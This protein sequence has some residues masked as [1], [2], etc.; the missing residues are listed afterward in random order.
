MSQYFLLKKALWFGFSL[1]LTLELA[2][3]YI[4]KNNIGKNQKIVFSDISKEAIRSYFKK[5]YT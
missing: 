4:E 3:Y 1:N 2:F 5:S